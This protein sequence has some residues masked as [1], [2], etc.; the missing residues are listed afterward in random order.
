[1]SLDWKT[2]KNHYKINNFTKS[3]NDFSENQTSVESTTNNINLNKINNVDYNGLGN[4]TDDNPTNT[5]DVLT[6]KKIGIGISPEDATSKLIV[7]ED[8]ASE[9]IYTLNESVVVRNKAFDGNVKF[10]FFGSYYNLPAIWAGGTSTDYNMIINPPQGGVVGNVGIGVKEP[11]TTLDVNGAIQANNSISA[12]ILSKQGDT[13]IVEIGNNDYGARLLLTDSIDG[14]PRWEIFKNDNTSLDFTLNKVQYMKVYKDN[15]FIEFLTNIRTHNIDVD[16]SDGKTIPNINWVREHVSEK[17]ND[18]WEVKT[19]QVQL[20][21]DQVVKVNKLEANGI[22]IDNATATI[23]F[24]QRNNMENTNCIK[25]IADE[26]TTR[27]NLIIEAGTPS[28]KGGGGH[29]ILKGGDKNNHGK[30]ANDREAGDAGELGNHRAGSVVLGRSGGL[31]YGSFLPYT[32]KDND[33]SSPGVPSVYSTHHG[34]LQ[35]YKYSFIRTKTCFCAIKY[36]RKPAASHP[37]ISIDAEFETNIGSILYLTLESRTDSSHEYTDSI[38]IE[39]APPRGT[40]GYPDTFPGVPIVLSQ[41]P[42]KLV[43]EVTTKNGSRA[44]PNG[45]GG[46]LLVLMYLGSVW[47]E[48]SYIPS[49]EKSLNPD[50]MDS[51]ATTFYGTVTAPSFI[52]TSDIDENNDND[53]IIPNIKWVREHVSTNNNDLWVETDQVQLKNDKVVKINNLDI[54][55][56]LTIKGAL[57]GLNLV[58]LD[59]SP[60]FTGTVTAQSFTATSDKNKKENIETISD[61][62][63]KIESL[64]GVSYNLKTDNTKTHYGVVA[65]ELEEVFPDMVHGE[66]GN[67]S[68]AYMEIIGVLIETVKDLNK[69]VKILEQTSNN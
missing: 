35:T 2:F 46:A 66:E 36:P 69:R 38:N 37:I 65:Q 53:K 13:D 63:S 10:L 12:K 17:K 15:M 27:T 58:K 47:K 16:D 8:N 40:D 1:M 43:N 32:F 30:W 56:T 42:R 6:A 7:N 4:N 44:Y 52:T 28:S 3:F 64:R 18:L 60:T 61:A 5:Y 50:P 33:F 55:G 29:L 51:F 11:Q 59:S 67:K 57:S 23:N 14:S 39:S 62:T 21:N 20:K 54:T 25:N 24:N 19:D 34:L 45:S 41:S 49:I 9:Y 22:N 48:I 26:N 31:C 68:V